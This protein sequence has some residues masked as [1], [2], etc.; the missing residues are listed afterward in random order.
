MPI[1]PFVFVFVG[2]LCVVLALPL[3]LR[4]V[5]PNPLYG[6]RTARTLRDPQVWYDANAYAGRLLVGSGVLIVVM[7]LGLFYL[8]PSLPPAVYAL[9]MVV[10]TTAAA[11]VSLFQAL[12][13]LRRLAEL[14]P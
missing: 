9:G 1:L 11:L 13:Y 8:V 2:A 7:T 5:K 10:V 12:R 6:F 3:V 14:A 4:W